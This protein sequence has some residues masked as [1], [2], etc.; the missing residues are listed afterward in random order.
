MT[1]EA[2]ALGGQVAARLMVMA[3]SMTIRTVVWDESFW[4]CLTVY[5]KKMTNSCPLTLSLR[6]RYRKASMTTLKQLSFLVDS[7]LTSLKIKQKLNSVSFL[8]YNIINIIW[9]HGLTKFFIWKG[10]SGKERALENCNGLSLWV[11]MKLT[12]TLQSLH[13]SQ[14]HGS[15]LPTYVWEE[16]TSLSKNTVII[17]PGAGALKGNT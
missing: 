1:R 2:H 9:I 17:L 3:V 13:P 14:V 8:N 6:S 16:Q 12:W 10:I 15:S 4:A 7:G 11:Q 5:Q